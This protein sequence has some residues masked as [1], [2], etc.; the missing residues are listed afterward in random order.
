MALAPASLRAPCHTGPTRQGPSRPSWAEAKA[1]PGRGEALL[2]HARTSIASGV[3]VASL[4]SLVAR[5]GPRWLRQGLSCDGLLHLCR[6]DLVVSLAPVFVLSRRRG[7]RIGLRAGAVTDTLNVTE[8]YRLLKQAP[9]TR[10]ALQLASRLRKAAR[11]GK[12]TKEGRMLDPG[13]VDEALDVLLENNARLRIPVKKVQSIYDEDE[14][15]EEL[16]NPFAR[17][18]QDAPWAEEAFPEAAE[19][20]EAGDPTLLA[21]AAAAEEAEDRAEE[22][23]REVG[24]RSFAE[25]PAEE[26]AEEL[27]PK[28]PKE[29]KAPPRW[30]SGS[31]PETENEED[32]G[33]VPYELWEQARGI[34]ERRLLF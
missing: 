12:R 26:T 33:D 17:R 10:H 25:L 30:K 27:P 16:S 28:E 32:D 18:K 22:F 13:I 31:S 7:S 5:T 15:E 21:Q 34:F 8:V 3:L 23:G 20:A 11:D 6:R 2:A 1:A 14:D 19:A 29:P 9:T 4:A 24:P